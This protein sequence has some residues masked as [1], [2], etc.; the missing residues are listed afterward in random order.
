M[1]KKTISL[2][3]M[4]HF[5]HK[6]A[7]Y[8]ESGMATTHLN[9]TM[10]EKWRLNCLSSQ[11]WPKT[12]PDDEISIIYFSGLVRKN[13]HTF[14]FWP[15]SGR[16]WKVACWNVYRSY[17]VH[18]LPYSQCCRFSRNI[19]E[20]TPKIVYFYYRKMYLFFARFYISRFV[21]PLCGRICCIEVG[22][23]RP[24]CIGDL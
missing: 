18:C 10:E 2:D 16:A 20:V 3:L 13:H 19:A 23:T 4:N 17:D 24:D 21:V 5:K 14:A 7:L 1:Y 9:E 15:R 6:H 8:V 22:L 11:I 12:I